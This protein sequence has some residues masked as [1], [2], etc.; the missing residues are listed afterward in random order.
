ML[1]RV[2]FFQ[3]FKKKGVH[4]CVYTNFCYFYF[5]C[6]SVLSAQEPEEG[7]RSP[8][9]GVPDDYELPDEFWEVNPGP[10]EAQSVSEPLS[11][12]SSPRAALFQRQEKGKD[13]PIAIAPAPPK[14]RGEDPLRPGVQS[15]QKKLG[16]WGREGRK[17]E[18]RHSLSQDNRLKCVFQGRQPMLP[19]G[20]GVSQE[21]SESSRHT[22]MSRDG[23]SPTWCGS[24]SSGAIK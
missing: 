2:A 22:V 19:W 17:E 24:V 9:T 23:L 11:H 3:G 10:L 6:M 13:W 18:K 14:R 16:S 7:D 5:L 8:R 20:V 15:Q 1:T 12:P 4:V 21:L